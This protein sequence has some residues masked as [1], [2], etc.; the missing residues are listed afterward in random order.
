MH[1]RLVESNGVVKSDIWHKGTVKWNICQSEMTCCSIFRLDL[2]KYSK[3]IGYPLFLESSYVKISDWSLALK[4]KVKSNVAALL[5]TCHVHLQL[6]PVFFE[7]F[8]SWKLAPSMDQSSPFLQ[9]IFQEDIQSCFA[10]TNTQV[11]ASRRYL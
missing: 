8:K 2:D 9:Q 1:S 4:V 5:M 3:C 7:L 6:D 10:F 11:Q